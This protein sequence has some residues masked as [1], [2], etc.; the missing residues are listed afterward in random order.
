MENNDLLLTSSQSSQQCSIC[1]W[2]YGTLNAYKLYKNGGTVSP[3]CLDIIGQDYVL[4]G[5]LGKPLLHV[6]PLN[7]QEQ[8]KNIRLILPEP[9]SCLAVCPNSN[10]LAVGIDCKIYIWQIQSGKLLSVQQKNFQPIT[11]VKFS[12]DGEYLLIGGQDGMLIVY[13][14][15]DLIS[16]S[17]N[18][19]TQSEVGQIEPVYTKTDHSLPI[20]DIHVGNFG[21]K[22]RFATV[23]ND[24]TC[25]VY[26]LLDGEALLTLVFNEVLTAVVFDAPCWHLF[27]GSNNGNINQYSLKNP[28]RTMSYHVSENKDRLAFKGHQKKIVC[29]EINSSGT[30]LASGSEDNFVFIWEIR[31]RQILKRIEH[32]SGITNIRFIMKYQ[33]FFYRT[34]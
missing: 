8:A 12:S 34:V 9:A 18:Y 6:W 4:S 30:V 17:N 15:C 13:T 10:Y 31:S 25:R 3:K 26:N 1:L 7:S 14:F 21:K 24:Q 16:C 5:E 32:K 28:P 19:L 27:I 29:L 33:N 20:R 22:S 23:S 11:S 2:D